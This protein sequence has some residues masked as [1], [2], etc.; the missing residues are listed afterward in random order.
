MPK[1]KMQRF[2]ELETLGNVL[3][4]KLSD[5]INTDYKYKG[6]WAVDFFKNSNPIILELACGKA[7][8]TIGLAEKHPEINFLGIDIKGERIW[9]GSKAAIEKKLTNVA[10]LRS[11]IEYIS[12]LFAKDEITEIWITFPDPRSKKPDIK[13]RLTSP[14]FIE[15]YKNIL[16]KE[17]IIHLK[18]DNAGLFEYTLEIIAEEKHE[19]LFK[20]HDL[21]ASDPNDILSIKTYYE[22]MF[23]GQGF[24]ICYLKFRINHT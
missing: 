20:T 23:S 11:R 12:Q 10:F 17:G 19:L 2:A 6:K 15:R 1:R 3:Q 18:T 13:K 16:I 7:E 22:Q 14:Q 4:P 5:I 9:I 21:Y 24:K 8:Y